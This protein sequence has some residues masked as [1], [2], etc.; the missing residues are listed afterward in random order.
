[1][2]YMLA[3]DG[4]KQDFVPAEELAASSGM[5]KT[6]PIIRHFTFDSRNNEA[7]GSQRSK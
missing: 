4:R 5:K 7:V 6:F 2:A 3:V 1:M